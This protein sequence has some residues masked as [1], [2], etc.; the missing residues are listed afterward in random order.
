MKKIILT[1]FVS[2]IEHE[3]P[4]VFGAVFDNPKGDEVDL[5]VNF[6]LDAEKHS[7]TQEPDKIP[8]YTTVSK[9]CDKN[10]NT[11]FNMFLSFDQIIKVIYCMINQSFKGTKIENQNRNDIYRIVAENW[12]V[13]RFESSNFES[14]EILHN[15][16]HASM[17]GYYKRDKFQK[18]YTY[19]LYNEEI[20]KW[21]TLINLLGGWIELGVFESENIF[22]SGNDATNNKIQFE[23][24]SIVF[25]LVNMKF[26][27]DNTQTKFSNYYSFISSTIEEFYNSNVEKSDRNMVRI[28]DRV[29]LISRTKSIELKIISLFG[30]IEFLLV[31]SNTNSDKIT[32]QIA[33]KLCFILLNRNKIAD[34]II[35]NEIKMMYSIRS[36]IAHGDYIDLEIE[37]QKLFVYYKTNIQTYYSSAPF[38][39]CTTTSSRLNLVYS[40]LEEFTAQLIMKYVEDSCFVTGLKGFLN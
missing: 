10:D 24:N 5:V 9:L 29:V 28:L 3:Y 19:L 4:F 36:K 40:R 25:D 34:R 31:S 13:I 16:L 17:S 12:I 23:L 1:K 18:E 8:D 2:P 11:A 7:F 30:L 37:L 27:K 20:Y 26:E 32:Y 15:E 6:L 35:A 39:N 22:L 14:E 38:E 21:S 33:E